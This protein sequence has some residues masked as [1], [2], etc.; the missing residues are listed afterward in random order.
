MSPVVSGLLPLPMPR[1]ACH[2]PGGSS[3]GTWNHVLVQLL[4]LPPCVIKGSSQV[5]LNASEQRK[6][7]SIL[8]D[9][10]AASAKASV[11]W[12]TSHLGL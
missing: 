2:R 11:S 9:N 4:L 10:S 7:L 6:F 3:R 1:M 5:A 12:K 8:L